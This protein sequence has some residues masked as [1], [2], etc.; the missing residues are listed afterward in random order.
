MK[1]VPSAKWVKMRSVVVTVVG[2]EGGLDD[3]MRRLS[4]YPDIQIS[5]NQSGSPLSTPFCT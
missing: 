2:G 3:L 5:Y 4:R 1:F